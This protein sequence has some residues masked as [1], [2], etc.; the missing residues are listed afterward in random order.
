MIQILSRKY[1]SAKEK[2]SFKWKIICNSTKKPDS[3]SM[4][5]QSV[6]CQKEFTCK[7]SISRQQQKK[8]LSISF[9]KGV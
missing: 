7:L 2:I 4:K 9:A 3:Q 8:C 5:L 6:E 1:F